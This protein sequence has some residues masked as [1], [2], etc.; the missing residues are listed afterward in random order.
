MNLR[1]AHPCP[2]AIS[3]GVLPNIVYGVSSDFKPLEKPVDPKFKELMAEFAKTL[4]AKVLSFS[5][6]QLR[7]LTSQPDL[8]VPRL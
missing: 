1:K 7:T 2:A 6:S 3:E 8:L 4:G 5:V